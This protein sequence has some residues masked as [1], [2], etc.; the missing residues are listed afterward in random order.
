MTGNLLAYSEISCSLCVSPSILRNL[1]STGD[2]L[3][4]ALTLPRVT[5]R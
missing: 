5:D 4:L 2:T 3:L 1:G